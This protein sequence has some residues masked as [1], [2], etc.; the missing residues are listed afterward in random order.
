LGEAIT[1][2]RA[3]RGLSQEQLADVAHLHITHI[4]GIER[5]TSNPS[6]ETLLKLARALEITPGALLTAADELRRRRK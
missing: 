3:E 6:F 4:G 2:L 5:G 1:V